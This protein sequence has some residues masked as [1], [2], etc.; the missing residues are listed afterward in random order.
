MRSKWLDWQPSALNTAETQ[1]S[2]PTKPG[3][4]GFEGTPPPLFSITRDVEAPADLNMEPLLEASTLP[5]AEVTAVATVDQGS[6][7]CATEVSNSPKGGTQPLSGST[8][9][10][11]GFIPGTKLPLPVGVRVISYTSSRSDTSTQAGIKIVDKIKFIKALLADLDAR[12]NHPIQIRGGGSVVEILQ[13]LADVGLELA[14]E[15][16][17]P[18]SSDPSMAILTEEPMPP[19]QK[20]AHVEGGGL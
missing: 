16:P 12:L 7:V 9:L 19:S 10:L 20:G 5:K 14:I 8:A 1:P 13:K 2:K 15:R 11:T 18:V 17:K 3:S 4:V 6:R